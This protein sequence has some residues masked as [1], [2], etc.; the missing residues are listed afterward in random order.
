MKAPTDEQIKPADDIGR[1]EKEGDGHYNRDFGELSGQGF[2]DGEA[3][4]IDQED[5]EKIAEN[6]GSH[7]V[8]DLGFFSA[9]HGESGKSADEQDLNDFPE[10]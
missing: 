2:V 8:D 10:K 4:S 7:P 5:A 9:V 3:E 6:D 1:K